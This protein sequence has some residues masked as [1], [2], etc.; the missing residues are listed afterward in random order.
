MRWL[1]FLKWLLGL[2]LAGYLAVATLAYFFQERLIF[3]P[4]AQASDYVYDWGREVAVPVEG[5]VA[6]STVWVD[7][8]AERGVLLYF[9]GNVGDNNRGLYQMRRVMELP[10]DLVFVDYRGFGKSGGAPE[11]DAQLLNDVQAVY[12]TVAAT[13]PEDQIHLLGYSL[14]TGMAAYL[15]AENSPAHLTLVAPYTSLDD[16][17][18]QLFW[19]LPGGLLKYHLATEDRIADIRCPIDIYH[20]TADELIPFEMSEALVQLSPKRATLHPLEGVGHRGAILSMGTEW[21]E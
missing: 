13:Y 4:R 19:W 5:D 10:Y 6:L 2:A 16:M 18:D 20:G 11:S 3:H 9:H 21:L 8:P 17:K 12:D 1:R 15:A 7:K 14:G